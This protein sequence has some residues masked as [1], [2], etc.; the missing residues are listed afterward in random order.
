MTGAPPPRRTG[1]HLFFRDLPAGTAI[2]ARVDLP[3]RE[4]VLSPHLHRRPIRARLRGDA[5]VAMDD[6]GADLTF[7]DPL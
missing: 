4:V 5:V 3:D 2:E 1:D 7:F 6:F